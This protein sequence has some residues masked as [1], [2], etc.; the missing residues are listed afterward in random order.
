TV[1]LPLLAAIGASRLAWGR[2]L[3]NRRN[4]RIAT[5]AV[6]GF[7]GELFGSVQAVKVANAE[8]DVIVHFDELNDIRRKSML[9]DRLFEEALASI[10]DTAITFGIGVTL[11]L[12]G[13]AM[14]SGAFTVGDFALFVY[15]LW[16][17][18][19]LP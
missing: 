1:F 15:Y 7:L 2:L 3:I 4:S 10:N 13:R 14:S 18:T 5:G 6:A 9:R 8:A 12:A 17:T 11:L 16:F 19:N